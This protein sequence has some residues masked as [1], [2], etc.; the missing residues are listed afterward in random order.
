[1]EVVF[2]LTSLV[3]VLS[4]GLFVH[5]LEGFFLW[6]SL[7]IRQ[8]RSNDREMSTSLVYFMVLAETQRG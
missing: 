1:V 4:P 3:H 8:V 2:N 5:R 6:V 7:L